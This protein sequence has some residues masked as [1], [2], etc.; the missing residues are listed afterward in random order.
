MIGSGWD[1][2]MN[3]AFIEDLRHENAHLV[4]SEKD[5]NAEGRVPEMCLKSCSNRLGEKKK[6][7]HEKPT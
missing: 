7:N 1:R 3:I 2:D 5:Q 4:R 6:R